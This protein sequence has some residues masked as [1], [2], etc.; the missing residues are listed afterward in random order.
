MGRPYDVNCTCTVYKQLNLSV[1]WIGPNGTVV[2]NDSSR[3]TTIF[4]STTSDDGYIH[5][6]TLQFSY[7]SEKDEN[8]SYNCN[9]LSEEHVLLYKPFTMTN[10]TSELDYYHKCDCLYTSD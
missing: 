10:L 9:I 3:I 4:E 5:T 7:I 2:T 1:S 6:S 8:T